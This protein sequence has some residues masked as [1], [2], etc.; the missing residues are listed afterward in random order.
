MDSAGGQGGPEADRYGAPIKYLKIDG[1][2]GL[3]YLSP[4]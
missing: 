2:T 4:L 3:F 1:F